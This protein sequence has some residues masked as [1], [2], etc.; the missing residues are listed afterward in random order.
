MSFFMP[1][2]PY[3]ALSGR[4]MSV[5]RA[6]SSPDLARKVPG[7]DP[8]IHPADGPR[9]Y[10]QPAP[11][12]LRPVDIHFERDG[13]RIPPLGFGKHHAGVRPE[14]LNHVVKDNIAAHK[15]SKRRRAELSAVHGLHVIGLGELQFPPWDVGEGHVQ[16][17]PP[18][19]AA[20][21]V[22]DCAVLPLVGKIVEVNGDGKQIQKIVCAVNHKIC[23]IERF[24]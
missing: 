9:P 21:P 20:D 23:G 13:V 11:E 2:T 10:W 3:G 1:S 8:T 17:R 4:E 5:G 15:R 18:A 16:R 14:A 24:G 6:S 19:V 12:R 22:R 7:V